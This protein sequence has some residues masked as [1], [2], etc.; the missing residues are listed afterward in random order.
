M[1]KN[2]I[3]LIL[4]IAFFYSAAFS[5][6]NGTVFKWLDKY[7]IGIRKSFD[8]SAK[9]EQK[10]AAIFWGED[11]K[12]NFSYWLI[13]IG[14]KISDFEL[15]KNS[16]SSLLA[17]P[18]IEWH[19]D[20][21]NREKEKNTLSAGLNLEFYPF[22]IQGNQQQLVAPWFLASANYQNDYIK[23]LKTIKLN[24][25]ISLFGTNAGWPGS[26]IRNKD[27]AL[28]LRYYP[29]TGIEYYASIDST[30]KYAT[31]WA[32]RI[33]FDWYPFSPKDIT[34]QYFQI[35][36]EITYRVKLSDNLYYK[37]NPYFA[38]IA[39]NIYPDGT[40]RFGFGVEYSKGNDPNDSFE[41][42]HR[43]NIGF[44]IKI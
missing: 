42:A 11:I 18:K 4:S 21:S 12:N 38:S 6:E 43:I 26:D 37:N 31:Y 29:Y 15:I 8:Q 25:S 27:Y 23:G 10:P 20:G 32:S 44:K 22:G 24:G 13:D 16:K 7:K 1:K 34:K 17:Y 3:V 36:V 41:M 2:I 9:D 28:V 35:N 30:K 39:A 40:D 5:E 14:I 19:K 33:Y